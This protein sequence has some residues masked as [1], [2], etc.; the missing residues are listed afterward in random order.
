[1]QLAIVSETTAIIYDKVEHNPL[2]VDGHIAWAAEVDLNALTVRALNPL[3]NTW[4]AT[5]SFLG[6]GTMVGSGGNPVFDKMFTKLYLGAS[7]LQAIRMFTP[8]DDKTCDVFEDPDHIHLTSNRWYAA[9]VRIEDGSIIIFGG[10]VVGGFTN[11]DSINNPTY[12]FFPPKN[13]NGHNGVQI[14]SQ[15]LHDTLNANHF[16]FMTYLPDGTIFVAANQNAMI[17]NWQANTETALPGIPNGVR[18]SS[19]FSAGAILLP[20]TPE[21]NYTPEVMICGGSTVSDTVLPSTISSQTPTSAQ[22]SRLVLNAAGIA[23]GWQ[24]ESMPQARIMPEM[25]LLPDGR[26]VIVNGAQTGVAGY[27][28]GPD[29]V[30]QS[31]ADN[32]AFTP[33]VYDPSAPAGSRFSSAGIPATDIARVYHSTASLTPNGTIMLAGSNPNVDVTTVKFPTEYRMEF[34]SP[35]YMAEPRPTYTGL[36]ATV[37]Y[38]EEFTLNVNLPSSATNVSVSLMDLGFATHGVHMDQRLLKLD[39]SLSDDGKVL[40]VTGPPTARLYP[41][42]P[43]YLFVVTDEGVPSF[44]HKT[45]IGTGASPPVDGDAAANMLRA[46]VASFVAPPPPPTEGEGSDVA[47]AVIPVSSS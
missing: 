8:C 6:N 25:I 10:S 22:C 38:G 42:G 47:T 30:G 21:N 20:L 14:P 11:S 15:F 27:G 26:I 36:P 32:P 43:A 17:F 23:A 12:E 19:P 33:V 31:D 45:I 37:N 4:C 1:M 16:P 3:S 18:I 13:I 39:S 2:T 9:S 28:S 46:S 5:G 41:P 7:G 44:G 35:P 29:P 24:V 40:T 34:Y